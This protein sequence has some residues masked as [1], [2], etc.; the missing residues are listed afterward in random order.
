MQTMPDF[1]YEGD[2]FIIERSK[3]APRNWK[4]LTDFVYNKQKYEWLQNHLTLRT[5]RFQQKLEDEK[6]RQHMKNNKQKVEKEVPIVEDKKVKIIATEKE[7][8]ALEDIKKTVLQQANFLQK[9]KMMSSASQQRSTKK[10]TPFGVQPQTTTA[11]AAR[12]TLIER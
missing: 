10:F 12:R 8:A 6:R 4:L 11:A 9:F 3:D 7:M 2:N 5:I 1:G